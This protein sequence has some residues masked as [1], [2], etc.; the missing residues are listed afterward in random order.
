MMIIRTAD[1]SD[2][3][4]IQ[5]IVKEVWPNA[6]KEVISQEQISYMLKMMY[7]DESLRKQ[8]HDE[9]CEFVLAQM[10]SNVVGFA[11]YSEVADGLFKL[12]K[13]Y[14]YSNQQGKGTGKS[15]LDEVCKRSS[16]RGGKS[17]ELQVNKKNKA[18]L[19]YERQDFFVDHE[20][21]FDIGN[22][23]VMDDFIMKK[24]LQ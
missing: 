2:L 11:S 10:N 21:V 18:K 24:W 9:G 14:V 15:L 5:S 7:D 17:I 1:L 8:M 12:H 16:N 4:Y 23:F 22:G 20:A 13:L 19:F 3:H 6:Y